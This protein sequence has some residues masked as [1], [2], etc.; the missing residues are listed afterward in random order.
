MNRI[1]PVSID[2]T[3]LLQ[4]S[5]ERQIPLHYTTGH[6]PPPSPPHPPKGN[7]YCLLDD[8]LSQGGK[9]MSCMS[10]NIAD[11]IHE[12]KSKEYHAFCCRMIW[13]LTAHG[14]TKVLHGQ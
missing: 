4:A 9:L 3:D 13:A 1:P 6:L 11:D 8:R 2:E 10:P 5:T 7:N 14:V 12:A